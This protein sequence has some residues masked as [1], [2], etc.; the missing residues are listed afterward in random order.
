MT[1]PVGFSPT[2]PSVA[3]VV[4]AD[5]PLKQSAGAQILLADLICSMARLCKLSL[6]SA[7]QAVGL[8]EANRL[9]TL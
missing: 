7:P 3:A 8:S 2:I 6:Y 4:S 5:V 1:H 9:L